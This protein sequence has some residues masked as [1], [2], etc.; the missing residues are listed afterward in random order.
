VA[1][2]GL[3]HRLAL[4]AVILLALVLGAANGAGGLLAMNGALGAG[5]LLAL[6]LALGTLAHRMADGR[7]LRVIALPL[8]L[9]MTLVFNGENAGESDQ[10]QEKNDLVHFSWGDTHTRVE[11]G[12][13]CVGS[14]CNPMLFTEY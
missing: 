1:A 4:G 9:G 11:V 7:A 2:S 5:N 14:V 12:R 8:A 13:E 10:S 3:A 6:H